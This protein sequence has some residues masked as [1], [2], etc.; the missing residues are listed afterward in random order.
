MKPSFLLKLVPVLTALAALLLLLVWATSH[1]GKLA[2]VARGPAAND[3]PAGNAASQAT[4]FP[5]IFVA[6]NEDLHPSDPFDLPGQ[7]LRFRGSHFDNIAPAP[8]GLPAVFKSAPPILWNIEVGEGYAA[9]VARDGRLYFLDYDAKQRADVL[10][11]L[12]LADGKDVWD[13]SYACDVKRNHGMSRTVAAISGDYIVTLG[14]RCDVLCVKIPSGDF[15][16]SLDLVAKYHTVVPPWYAGQCPLIDNDRVIFG[17]G[18]D[19]LVVALDLA[20]GKPVW[21][22][23]NPHHWDM[24]HSSIMPMTL[25]GKKMY[26][27]CASGGVA[28]VSVDDGS[29][30]WETSAWKVSLAT[31]PSPIQIGE[32][33]MLLCGGYGAGAMLLRLRQD[34]GKFVPEVVYRLP[35]EVFGSEQQTPVLYQRMI[36]GVLPPERKYQLACFDPE[37]GT[38]KWDSGTQHFGI[39]PFMIIG[40]RIF[41]M[42]DSGTLSIVQASP[43]GFHLQGQWPIFPHGREAWG[44]MALVGTRLLVRDITHLACLDLTEAAHE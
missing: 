44:P 30:L 17:P 16:W 24:T 42:N 28:G 39:G 6:S 32:D 31:V 5:T 43:D 7:W 38:Q 19:A 34:N 3:Q 8:S 41:L 11:C 37:T 14:P 27:Y 25:L 36:Y 40:D 35:P 1:D 21:Q 10:R 33:R 9:P 20:T 23:P 15:C 2:I 26:V 18:A 13:L 29:L 12:R 22:T 4:T